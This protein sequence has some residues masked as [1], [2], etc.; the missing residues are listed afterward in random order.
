M[1]DLPVRVLR[2]IAREARELLSSH[3]DAAA[4]PATDREGAEAARR[5]QRATIPA[6][7]HLAESIARRGGS[8]PDK[9]SVELDALAAHAR[10]RLAFY[11]RRVYLGRGEGA[12]LAELE[13]ASAG[14]QERA[15]R[16]R[17]GGRAS[18]DSPTRSKEL[19]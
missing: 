1:T 5:L 16:A 9:R 4:A 17:R 10:Q 2:R 13:R 6:D 15:L 11:R 3:R 14:A 18:V 19:T 12:K 8:T 7:A